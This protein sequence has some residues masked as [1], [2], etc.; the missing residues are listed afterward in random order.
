MRGALQA[1]WRRLRGQDDPYWDAFIKRPPH[2]PQHDYGDCGK[3]PE[4]KIFPT[5]SELH[6]PNVTARHA[7]ELTLYLGGQI[8]GIAD[9]G[10]Q[11]R[12]SRGATRTLS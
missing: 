1:S 10:R 5:P 6:S 12:R 7:K 4:G 9:L 11:S 2:E 8:V 3:A